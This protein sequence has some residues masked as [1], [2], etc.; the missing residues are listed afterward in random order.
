M[1]TARRQAAVVLAVVLA[2]CAGSIVEPARHDR[3]PSLLTDRDPD[4]IKA[5]PRA[6]VP[7][8][9]T[10]VRIPGPQNPVDR[11]GR[12][13]WRGSFGVPNA[14]KAAVAVAETCPMAGDRA[15]VRRHFE[16]ALSFTIPFQ[17]GMNIRTRLTMQGATLKGRWEDA[18]G[19]NSGPVEMALV[20]RRP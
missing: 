11:D 16:L 4:A 6:F 2:A 15:K 20:P 5:G 12:V 3:V 13:A 8:L 9:I 7:S 1:A 10:E 18:K 19:G 17:G 14:G